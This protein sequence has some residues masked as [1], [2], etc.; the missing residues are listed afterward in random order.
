[1]RSGSVDLCGGKRSNPAE[2]DEEVDD[3]HENP[4]V[5]DGTVEEESPPLTTS[6][7]GSANTYTWAAA[8]MAREGVARIRSIQSKYGRPTL[9]T[10]P[11]IPPSVALDA[12]ATPLFFLMKRVV[13]IR[14]NVRLCCFVRLHDHV[15]Q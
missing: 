13:Y 14:N 5:N 7:P 2:M 10:T 4:V 8:V 9:Q 1:M 11:E 15:F 12:P 6:Y 3:M